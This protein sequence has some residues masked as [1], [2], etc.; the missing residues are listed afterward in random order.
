[1]QPYGTEAD[2]KEDGGRQQGATPLTGKL[3]ERERKRLGQR[4]RKQP[5]LS[6]PNFNMRQLVRLHQMLDYI[7]MYACRDNFSYSEGASS[8]L[9]GHPCC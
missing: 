3:R 2:R 5:G 1:M 6:V 8:L 9:L 7:H 4:V